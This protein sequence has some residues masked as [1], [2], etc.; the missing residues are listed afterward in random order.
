MPTS[1]LRH[2]SR[3]V[4]RHVFRHVFSHELGRVVGHASRRVSSFVG[5]AEELHFEKMRAVSVPFFLVGG[6]Y[7]SMIMRMHMPVHMPVCVLMRA[8][9]CPSRWHSIINMP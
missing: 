9:M 4:L 5:Q 1:V 2:V 7:V 6:V 3:R 8:D